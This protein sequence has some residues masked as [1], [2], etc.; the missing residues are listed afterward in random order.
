[1]KDLDQV[2]REQEEKQFGVPVLLRQYASLGA[3]YSDIGVWPAF[4]QS[5]VCLAI[6]AAATANRQILGARGSG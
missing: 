2:I 3:V 6:L 5:Y 4:D 1:M